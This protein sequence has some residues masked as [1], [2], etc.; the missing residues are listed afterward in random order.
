MP[1]KRVKKVMTLPI[2]VIFGH[3]Q[4][5]TRVRI[6]LYE[7]TKTQIE[8]QIIGFDEYMNMTL[9]DAVEIGKTRIEVGRIL[10]KGDAI[11]L[12]QEAHPEKKE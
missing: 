9:D 3:L 2:N 10:L 8:G 5:K 11:T 12:I 1:P 6:W 4:K 7:D